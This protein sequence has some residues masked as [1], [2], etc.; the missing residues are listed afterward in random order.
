[1]DPTKKPNAI[2]DTVIQQTTGK[3]VVTVQLNKEYIKEVLITITG[4]QNVVAN[5][6]YTDSAAPG[7]NIPVFSLLIIV[8]IVLVRIIMDAVIS[9]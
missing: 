6:F 9:I 8:C 2:T 3:I 7:D 1:M 5:V 4:A